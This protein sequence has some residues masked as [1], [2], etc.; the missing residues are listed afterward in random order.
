MKRK[1]LNS[2]T[3]AFFLTFTSLFIYS[4]SLPLFHLFELK[5]YDLKV[6]ARGNRPV[7]GQIV[8]VAVD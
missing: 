5:S 8:I 4:L 7:S 1:W 3:V 2:F 6:S